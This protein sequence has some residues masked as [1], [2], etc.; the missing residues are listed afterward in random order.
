VIVS[1][2][3]SNIRALQYDRLMELALEAARAIHHGVH[4]V[5]MAS[6]ISFCTLWVRALRNLL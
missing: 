1:V 6:T 2:I 3:V 5:S 4:R